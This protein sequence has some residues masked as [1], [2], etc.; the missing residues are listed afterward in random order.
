MSR[1]GRGQIG[2]EDH[3]PEARLVVAARHLAGSSCS[4]T[5]MT[6]PS[7]PVPAVVGFVAVSGF[8]AVRP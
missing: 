6:A 3:G 1:R 2:V 5:R 8:C 7:L 4:I